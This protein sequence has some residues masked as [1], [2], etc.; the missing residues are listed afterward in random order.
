MDRPLYH[1]ALRLGKKARLRNLPALR[2]AKLN[3]ARSKKAQN[4]A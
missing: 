1:Q 4:N 2:S 3:A